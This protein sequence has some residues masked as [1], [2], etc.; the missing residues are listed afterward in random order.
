MKLLLS[1]IQ[2]HSRA[3][4]VIRAQKHVLLAANQEYETSAIALMIVW[5]GRSSKTKPSHAAPFAL[6][7]QKTGVLCHLGHRG[8]GFSSCAS[9]SVSPTAQI[10]T[11]LTVGNCRA[12]I[13]IALAKTNGPC[14]P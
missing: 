9:I 7:P 14:E 5:L 3:S 13:S 10:S 6:F 4:R 12:V 11:F 1:A 2:T 8:N